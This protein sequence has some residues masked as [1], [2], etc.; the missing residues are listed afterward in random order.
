MSADHG[1]DAGD[2]GDCG[3]SCSPFDALAAANVGDSGCA[4]ATNEPLWA[5]I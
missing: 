5:A 3:R 4:L 2:A 1:G